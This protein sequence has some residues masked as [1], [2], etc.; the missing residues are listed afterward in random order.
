MATRAA[1]LYIFCILRSIAPKVLSSYTNITDDNVTEVIVS[2]TSA[3]S[4]CSSAEIFWEIGV[5]MD[6]GYEAADPP[7]ATEANVYFDFNYL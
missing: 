2:K 5:C 7:I 1:F 4:F 6:E 3:N